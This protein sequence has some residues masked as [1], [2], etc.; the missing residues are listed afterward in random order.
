MRMRNTDVNYSFITAMSYK[1]TLD[2]VGEF[3]LIVSIVD[4]CI[5][6]SKVHSFSYIISENNLYKNPP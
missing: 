6:K 1:Q 2:K 3:I 4:F 5:A